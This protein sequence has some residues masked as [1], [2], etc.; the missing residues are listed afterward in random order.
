MPAYL[1]KFVIGVQPFSLP[2][3]ALDGPVCTKICLTSTPPDLH[4]TTFHITSR[5]RTGDR[6]SPRQGAGR[7]PRFRHY[8]RRL[9]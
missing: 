7:G 3:F 6:E 1:G 5:K 8:R 4:R 9:Q 2:S